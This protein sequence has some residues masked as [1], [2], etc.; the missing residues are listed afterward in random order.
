MKELTPDLLDGIKYEEQVELKGRNGESYH[1]SIRPLRSS[2]IARV[3]R[4][5][6]ASI[7]IRGDKVGNKI[8][9]ESMETDAGSMAEAKYIAW[10]EASALATIDKAWTRDLIDEKWLPEWVEQVGERAFEISTSSSKD[11]KDINSF[12]KK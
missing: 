10:L 9:R 12:R 7:K 11:G 6:T 5:S 2:E 1:V 4:I 3:Q 8:S